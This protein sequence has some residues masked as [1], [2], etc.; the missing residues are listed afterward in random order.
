MTRWTSRRS[1][2]LSVRPALRVA[3]F[4]LLVLGDC[5]LFIPSAVAN[6]SGT[7]VAHNYNQ[8]F[9]LELVQSRRNQVLGHYEEIDLQANGTVVTVNAQVTGAVDRDTVVL[10]IKPDT[11]F[12][13]TLSV[14]GT[15]SANHLT[16][17]GGGGGISINLAMTRGTEDQ[18]RSYMSG[19]E[20]SSMR[21]RVVQ[22]QQ[23]LRQQQIATNQEDLKRLS[24]IREYMQEFGPLAAARERY[25][26]LS[27]EKYRR[28]TSIMKATYIR[29]RTIFAGYRTVSD[30]SQMWVSIDQYFIDS[31]DV[32]IAVENH[33]QAFETFQSKIAEQIRAAQHSCHE[34]RTRSGAGQEISGE[35]LASACSQLSTRLPYFIQAMNKLRASYQYVGM[36]WKRERLEQKRILNAAQIAVNG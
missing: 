2:C 25:L 1:S 11:I 32:H 13:P 15:F 18:F 28:I 36:V 6:A 7:Y 31:G 21:I 33:F 5:A 4:L 23:R 20:A 35:S 22:A 9:L 19:L 34:L 12:A 17:S 14:S 27:G 3:G 24:L 26:T 16:L 10:T 29:E 8:A 30:R